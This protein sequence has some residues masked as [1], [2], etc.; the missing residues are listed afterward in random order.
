[1]RTTILA[2]MA[3]AA[4]AAPAVGQTVRAWGRNDYGQCNVPS[5][6]GPCTAVAGGAAHTVAVTGPPLPDS[7]SDGRPDAYD[8][9]PNAYNPSQADCDNDGIGDA[10]DPGED[11]NGNGIPDHCECIADLFV[12]GVVNGVDLGVLLAYWGPTTSSSASQRSDLND[13]HGHAVA[14]VEDEIAVRHAMTPSTRRRTE[15]ARRDGGCPAPPPYPRG[16]LD[17]GVEVPS[18]RL[19]EAPANHA[20]K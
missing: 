9:C 17:L 8:N 20:R 2:V 11:F 10:C 19:R 18:E 5:D 15:G 12:D 13:A 1:M 16:R 6:L 4:V 14:E 7:D 3:A